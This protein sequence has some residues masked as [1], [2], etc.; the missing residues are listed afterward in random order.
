MNPVELL[1]FPDELALARAAAEAWLEKIAEAHLHGLPHTVALAGG[2][3]ARSLFP[4]VAE[5]SRARKRRSCQRIRYGRTVF[6]VERRF[7]G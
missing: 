1:T 7:G 5:G 2:R 4:A 3:A 6:A